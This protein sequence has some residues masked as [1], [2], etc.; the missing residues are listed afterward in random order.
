[1]SLSFSQVFISRTLIKQLQF[2]LIEF[3]VQIISFLYQIWTI[4]VKFY[5]CIGK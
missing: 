5:Y 3:Y 2:K 4:T 1:M